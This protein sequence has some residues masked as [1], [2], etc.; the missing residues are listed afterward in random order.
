MSNNLTRLLSTWSRSVLCHSDMWKAIFLNLFSL[1]SFTHVKINYVIL[2]CSFYQ[3]IHAG[4]RSR[5]HQRRPWTN[6]ELALSSLRNY[7]TTLC[8]HPLTSQ[9][10]GLNMMI[11]ES[12]S[13]WKIFTVQP[14]K[15]QKVE[16]YKHVPALTWQPW[17]N[18]MRCYVSAYKIKGFGTT[19][20][21]DLSSVFSA[22]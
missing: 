10:G 20:Q 3:R 5:L 13:F 14:P 1:K 6:C 16:Y 9:I 22:H 8:A 17:L 18:R 12:L 21:C 19:K 4:N 7:S 2:L 15:I 11:F